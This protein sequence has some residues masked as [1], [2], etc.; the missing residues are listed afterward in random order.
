VEVEV[1]GRLRDHEHQGVVWEQM[2]ALLV[3]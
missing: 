2:G 3:L 1:E